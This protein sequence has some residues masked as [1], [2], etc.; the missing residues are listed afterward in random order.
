MQVILIEDVPN[1]GE[2]GQEVKVKPGYARNYLLPRKLAVTASTGGAKRLQHE[3]RIAEAKAKRVRVA[4]DALAKKL[5]Q[6][7]LTI[8]RKVGEQEKL[9]GSVTAIDI[10][11][12][13][14]EEKLPVDR[15]KILL[16]EPIKTLGVFEVPVRLRQ[17]LETKIK[18]WVVAE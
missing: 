9:F 8:A 7:S 1:L 11:A 16:N 18:V 3:K 10:E 13:L 2:I 12:A 15:R 5:E 4:D 17:D 14:T 6:L